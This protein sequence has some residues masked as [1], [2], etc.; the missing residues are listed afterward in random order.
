MSTFPARTTVG[1][2]SR[3]RSAQAACEPSV[4]HQRRSC[5]A[6]IP[7]TWGERSTRRAAR[8]SST[9][10]ASSSTADA[11][12][13][14]CAAVL[15]DGART[16]MD[17]RTNQAIHKNQAQPGNEW[18]R[19]GPRAR[20]TR[21]GESPSSRGT[22]VRVTDASSRSP[23]SHPPRARKAAHGRTRSPPRPPHPL[24]G[25]QRA[26]TSGS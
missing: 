11:S 8:C 12:D 10:F 19:R 14:Y 22:S 26:D 9:M 25:S 2:T 24:K 6:W 3:C 15:R 23:G 21:E 16:P 20:D 1:S 17:G 4:P 18:E 5:K 13:P 7:G